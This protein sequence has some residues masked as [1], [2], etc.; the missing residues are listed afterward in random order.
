MDA[1]GVRRLAVAMLLVAGA[2]AGTRFARPAVASA[3][4]YA[5]CVPSLTSV[6]G[7]SLL[8]LPNTHRLV[9]PIAAPGNL[10]ACSLGIRRASYSWPRL[11]VLA[12]DPQALAPDPTTVALRTRRFDPSN[13]QYFGIRTTFS[14]PVVTQSLESVADGRLGASALQLSHDAGLLSNTLWLHQRTDAA[15]SAPVSLWGPLGQPLVPLTGPHASLA[16]ALCG[17]STTI[18]DYRVVQAVMTTDQ[19]IEPSWDTFAQHFRV[20]TPVVLHW[21]EIANAVNPAAGGP[22][23]VQ[24]TLHEGDASQPPADLSA[25]LT[26]GV[27]SEVIGPSTNNGDRS[28]WIPTFD[29]DAQVTLLPGRGYWLVV[30]DA[31]QW[32]MLTR[33]RT[34]L[35]SPEY[36][37]AIGPLL[38]RADEASPWI[39]VTGR[40]LSFRLI[41]SEATVIDVPGSS[42]PRA[43]LALRVH[44][45]PAR[46]SLQLEWSGASEPVR[47]DVLD[48]SGRVVGRVL[49][50][51]GPSGSRRWDGALA[52]AKRLPPGVYLLRATS[53]TAPPVTQRVVLLR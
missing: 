11:D 4:A 9:M 16:Q 53:G 44:P 3:D 52:H 10:A 20:A 33:T 26:R 13:V 7:D 6:F 28:R 40:D 48:T 18:A 15:T 17:G 25:P 47:I 43:A 8:M 1:F 42:T 27:T 45:N 39:S 5:D 49:D 23:P 14:P 51:V 36:V 22:W 46:G 50:A 32:R 38:R 2:S 41:G 24:V 37:A 21:A 19:A 12:W 31:F 35:E 30:R 29:F 34:G